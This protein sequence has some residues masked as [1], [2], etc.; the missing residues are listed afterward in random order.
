MALAATRAALA[1]V[2]VLLW[3]WAAPAAWADD[4]GT[5]AD[6]EVQ[7]AAPP[8]DFEEDPFYLDEE[9]KDEEVNDPFEGFN[10]GIFAFNDGLERWVLNPVARGWDFVM[11]N[12]AQRAVRNLF[13][14]LQFPIHFF[15]NLLQAKPVRAGTDIARFVMNSTVG[16]AG[17]MDPASAV[18]LAKSEE[19]FGQTF[20]YWGIPAGPFVMLPIFGPRNARDTVGLIADSA[21]LAVGFFIPFW[22]SI[23]IGAADRL[24]RHSLVYK[25]IASERKAALDWYAAVRSFYTQRREN[26]IRDKREP[27]DRRYYSTLGGD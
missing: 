13:D 27:A 10:R 11:P 7:Q 3:L 6:V 18:G 24:N 4:T 17:L 19:D 23:A 2:A 14:N 1:G 8:D 12:F 20:G 22:G 5:Q 9:A 21:A 15:N 26:L 25:E 16:I